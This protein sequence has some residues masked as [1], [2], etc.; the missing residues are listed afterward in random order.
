MSGAGGEGGA[1]PGIGPLVVV[2]EVK[3]FGPPADFVEF[4]NAGDAIAD[5]S[6]WHF[7]DEDNNDYTF[8][9]GTTLAP[10]AFLGLPQATFGF[11]LGQ[12]DGV[13]LYDPLD[14]LMAEFDWAIGQNTA[15]RCPDGTGAF[16]SGL[17]ATLGAANACGGP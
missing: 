14:T 8:P 6:G 5:L 12:D 13:F 17:T 9:A 3:T 7:T 2:N 11:G 10:G 4:Y 1:P 15:G 16:Q